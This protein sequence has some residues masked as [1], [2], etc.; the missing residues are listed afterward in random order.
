MYPTKHDI[1]K[2]SPIG[3]WQ[4]WVGAPRAKLQ[5]AKSVHV[6]QV[7]ERNGKPVPGTVILE[8]V[9]I[10]R[11][12]DLQT[13][14]YVATHLNGIHA[15][16]EVARAFVAELHRQHDIRMGQMAGEIFPIRPPKD[17]DK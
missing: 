5:N 11:S 15:S 2:E 1:A 6:F 4:V 12:P 9:Q 8:T 7:I 16:E 13:A 14:T 3:S 17:N 10:G